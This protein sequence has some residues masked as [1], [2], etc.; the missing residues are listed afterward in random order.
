MNFEKLLGKDNLI[1]KSLRAK[2][3]EIPTKIQEESIP[4]ILEGN[5]IIAGASTG[6]GKTLAFAVGLI[7]NVKKNFGVQGLVLTPTRELANQVAK[8]IALFSEDKGLNV[9]SIY[10]GVSIRDQIRRL[11]S[12][13]IV[14]GT[15]GRIL[16]HLTR[17]SLDLSQINTL[18][19]DEADHMLDMGF[20]DDVEKIIS[21]CPKKRQTLLFSATISEDVFY[22]AKKHMQN[23]IEIST[24][25]HVDPMK[26]EQAYYNAPKGLKYSL[27]KH[28]LENEKSKLVMIFC[29]TRRNVDFISKNLKFMGIETLP[30]HGGFSQEKRTR[31]LRDFHSKKVHI[32]V[33]T[34]VA[35]RGLDIKGV[36]HIYNYDLPSTKK[37]YIHRIGR[38]ARAGKQGKVINLV[39]S[40]DYDNFG[41]VMTGEFNIKEEK[42]PFIERVRIRWM[43]EK[44]GER[45]GRRNEQRGR[46][47]QGREYV[48]GK[49]E[50]RSSRSFHSKSRRRNSRNRDSRKR[51]FS[52]RSSSNR[53]QGRGNK[54]SFR[55]KR[56]RR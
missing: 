34:D 24:E 48:G 35:A 41:K 2:G 43:P 50:H 7:K 6:S 14:V 9:I 23:L 21:Y 56:G 29:N 40:R 55:G 1:L 32:L 20:I 19:L 18:V 28:L 25:P 31:M 53:N 17:K 51:S 10:G 12:S 54:D 5:D 49:N 15:P 45:M 42:A 11:A 44:R 33:A 26:L 30:I 39:E 3:F 16:D 13:E 8:E 46:E 37:E 47:N 4:K 38:T 27:L 36:T 52:S 22:L